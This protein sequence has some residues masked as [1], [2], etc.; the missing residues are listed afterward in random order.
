MVLMN[1]ATARACPVPCRKF[2]RNAKAVQVLQRYPDADGTPRYD[3]ITMSPLCPPEGTKKRVIEVIKDVTPRKQLEEALQRFRKKGSQTSKSKAFLETIVNG[4]QDHMMVID[5]D[6]RV[7]EVNRA[8]LQMV[9]QRREE[10]VGK[11][12]YEVSHHL[13]NPC[14][15][16]DHPCPLKDAVATGKAASA[17]HVHFDKKGRERYYHVVCHPLYDEN[18]RIHQVV[19]LARDITQEITARTQ[20]LHDDKMTSLG[21]LSASVVHEINNPLTGILNFIKLMQRLLGKA[22]RGEEELSNCPPTSIWSIMKPPGSAKR[23]PTCWPFPVRPS[24]NSGR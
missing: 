15:C 1:P 10:V 24:R 18:G 4:I 21:K 3:E 12:C 23:C 9:G 20:V 2:W 16:P 11:H 7:I 14:T 17:T 13:K 8:L 19:D 22:A 5:L 6:Y